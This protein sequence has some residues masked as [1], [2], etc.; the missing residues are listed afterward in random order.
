MRGYYFITD[1]SLSLAGNASDVASAAQA[2]VDLV[3]YRRKDGSFRELY[4]EALE[5]RRACRGPKF[6][7]NDRVDVALA[8]NAD[9]VHLGQDDMPLEIARQLLGR[10]RV[11]GVTAHNITEA[12]EAVAGGADYIGVSPVFST[13]TKLDAGEPAGLKLV[14][15]V[16]RAVKVP[17][18]AIGGI[19]L[20]NAPSVIDAGADM[21]CAI[22]AVITQADVVGEIARFQSLFSEA[23]PRR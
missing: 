23:R 4:Q 19:N 3:Q 12:V 10:H 6:L 17:V 1:S 20:Q 9:G 11:I 5:L 15:D 18:I 22:S 14:A 2:G 7:I 16:R 13:S 8:V 21:V